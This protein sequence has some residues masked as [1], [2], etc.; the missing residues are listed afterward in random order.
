MIPSL[1][2]PHRPRRAL[3]RLLEPNCSQCLDHHRHRRP[4]TPSHRSPHRPRRALVRLLEPNCSQCLDHHRHRRPKT[5]SHRSARLT[6]RFRARCLEPNHSTFPDPRDA[7][8][9][10]C[11]HTR[12]RLSAAIVDTISSKISFS[13]LSSPS[14]PIAICASSKRCNKSAFY[15]KAPSRA[16]F[17]GKPFTRLKP[18]PCAIYRKRA[19]RRAPHST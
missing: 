9:L 19:K 10:R 1:R 5:P 7:T 3:V 14:V 12:P 8:H 6:R 13:A 2:S 16:T 11:P 15:T 17:T 18:S 4:K